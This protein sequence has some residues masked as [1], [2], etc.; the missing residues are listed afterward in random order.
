M[1]FDTPQLAW[2]SDVENTT[3][4]DFHPYEPLFA[5]GGSDS[6]G[7]NVFLRL[8]KI[9]LD[10]LEQKAGTPELKKDNVLVE[11]IFGLETELNRGH[12]ATI[13]SCHFSPCGLFLATGGDDNRV[14][15][16]T[17]KIKPKEFESSELAKVWS[18]HR[19]LFGHSKEVYDVRWFADCKHIVSASLDFRAIIWDIESGSIVQTIDGHHSNYIKGCSIDPTGQHLLTLSTDRTVK[20]FKSVKQKKTQFICKHVRLFLMLDHQ[21]DEDP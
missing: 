11:S 7:G 3:C 21:T 4:I 5:V 12:S 17:E 15:I 16:W 1:K 2:H 14:I 9:K 18:D 6:T 19:E 8:W 20:I 10:L 13:N